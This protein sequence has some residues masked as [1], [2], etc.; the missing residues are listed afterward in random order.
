MLEPEG[1][2]GIATDITPYG[3][4]EKY[5]ETGAYILWIY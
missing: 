5:L 4:I 1:L 2:K 3:I